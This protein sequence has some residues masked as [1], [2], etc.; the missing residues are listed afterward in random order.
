MTP[1]ELQALA[2]NPQ[3]IS[4]IYNYC[5]R[6][7]ERCHV[8]HKCLL[9][10]GEKKIR[11][12]AGEDSTVKGPAIYRQLEA[13]FRLTIDLLNKIAREKGIDL[14][15][16]IKSESTLSEEE[17]IK[18]ELAKSPLSRLAQDY[19]VRTHRWIHTCDTAAQ[20]KDA[21]LYQAHSLQIPGR[22][23]VQ[24]LEEIK[25]ALNVV[26]WYYRQIMIKLTRA[27]RSRLSESENS[28]DND[29]YPKDSNGSAKV[30]IQGIERSIGAWGILLNHLPDQ[31]EIILNL[32]SLLQKLLRIA[33]AEFPDARS[34][35]RTGI[36]GN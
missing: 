26:H 8:T 2:K 35:Y 25:E 24:E 4:G 36:D 21:D 30:A 33:D 11:D 28:E 23:P 9:F 15:E 27:Q 31:E 13:S 6:W 34:F 22:D 19:L 12:K 1:D 14:A 17:S 7:C 32:L 3:F 20:A 16:E 10:A 5:D 29:E 18:N